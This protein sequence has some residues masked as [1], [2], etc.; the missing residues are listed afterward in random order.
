MKKNKVTGIINIAR[1][2]EPRLWEIPFDKNSFNIII[3]RRFISRYKLVSGTRITCTINNGSIETILSIAGRKPEAFANRNNFDKLTPL[4]PQSRFDFSQSQS[5]SLRIIDRFAPVGKGTRGLI[6]SPPRSGKTTILTDIANGLAELDPHLRVI[7]LL[8]DERPEEVTA[9]KRS[10]DAL[11]Y[12]SS[13]DKGTKSHI[14]LSSL[15]INHIKTEVE[16]GNDIVILIDSLTRLSRA[17]NLND[18]HSRGRTLSGGLGAQAM[19]VPRKL[20]GLARNTEE[21]GSC[22]ILATIL[23]DTGSRLDDVIFQ[24]FKGTGNCEIILDRDLADERIFPAINVRESGTRRDEL[25]FSDEELERNY[26]MR[27]E[28]LKLDKATAIQKLKQTLNN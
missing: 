10:T 24:E 13:L 3:P 27:S 1:N 23:K 17:Y 4:N 18:N 22:T 8:I 26:R 12:H 19:S 9:F 21:G 28:I 7:V 15:L 6:V 14:I 16:C 25:F 20:F 5:D 11:I 2:H